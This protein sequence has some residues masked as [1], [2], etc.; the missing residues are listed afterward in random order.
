[1]MQVSVDQ[2]CTNTFQMRYFRFGTGKAP[3]VILPG[4]SVQSVIGLAEAVASVYAPLAE[5]FTVYVFDR[6]ETLP[7]TYDIHAMADDTAAALYALG[8]RS[9]CLFGASQGGMIAMTLAINYPDLVK[10]LAVGSSAASVSSEQFQTVEYW[11]HLAS[12]QDGAA[13]YRDFGAHIYPPAV[14]EK[15]KAALTFAG[16]S[17]TAA[18]FTRF[19]TLAESIRD[20]S[21]L[22]DLCKI[23][24]P[25]LVL[26]D[27]DDAVLGAASSD[28]IAAHLSP[29][30]PTILFLSEG[31]GHAAYD[32]APDYKTRLLN[33]FLPVDEK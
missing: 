33:F 21:V 14:F 18:E 25:V 1:M 17:V 29:N 30:T 3:L 2:V 4:L 11:I 6:R 19:I 15:Y 23:R 31:Y 22:N 7:P 28:E 10:K 32:L 26:G 5:D 24:C 20:F 27:R 13:L 8:L 9:V 16:R 12:A